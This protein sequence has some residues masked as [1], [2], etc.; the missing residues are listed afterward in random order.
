MTDLHGCRRKTQ[1]RFGGVGTSYYAD[2]RHPVQSPDCNLLLQKRM[3]N[4]SDGKNLGKCLTGK[5]VS[6]CVS[7]HPLYLVV[8]ILVDIG[9]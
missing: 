4:M 9:I 3:L 2:L 6:N 8:S 7:D 5:K 1:V